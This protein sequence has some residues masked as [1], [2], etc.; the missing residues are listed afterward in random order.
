MTNEKLIERLALIKKEVTKLGYDHFREIMPNGLDF[1]KKELKP[2]TK[3][4]TEF[5]KQ[6]EKLKK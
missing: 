5:D 3:L 2:F 4:E 1:I 6:I